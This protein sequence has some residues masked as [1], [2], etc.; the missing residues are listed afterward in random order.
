MVIIKASFEDRHEEVVLL[1]HLKPIFINQSLFSFLNLHFILFLI[2]FLD[3]KLRSRMSWNT[4]RR[5][6]V[7]HIVVVVVVTCNLQR[8]FLYRR[9]GVLGVVV[10]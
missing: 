7:M 6:L 2:L 3:L 8:Q 10:N 9:K 1:F 4:P 5:F